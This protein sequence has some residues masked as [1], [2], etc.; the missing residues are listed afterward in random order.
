[1]RVLASSELYLK[2]NKDKVFFIENGKEE[3]TVIKSIDEVLSLL[4][5]G[6]EVAEEREG[7]FLMLRRART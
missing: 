4:D 3:T 1:M 5:K 2:E 7:S 6:W